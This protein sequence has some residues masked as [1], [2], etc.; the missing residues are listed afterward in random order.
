MKLTYSIEEA[1]KNL[2]NIGEQ[3]EM[4]N[5]VSVIENGKM[6]FGILSAKA[7]SRISRISR[8]FIEGKS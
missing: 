1:E 5:L 8:A 4:G 3:V 7:I 6:L 2:D